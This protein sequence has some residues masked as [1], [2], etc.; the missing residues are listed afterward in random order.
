MCL[1]RVVSTPDRSGFTLV[2]LLVVILLMLVLAALAVLFVP[3]VNERR[4]SAIAAEQVQTALLTAKQR[5]VRDQAPR[6]VRIQP[7]P[8]VLDAMGD[9]S[10]GTQT[11]TPGG[12]TRG[13][14]SEGLVWSMQAPSWVIV[15]DPD[16]S[17]PN[18]PELFSNVE[19]VK[20]LSV[21]PPGTF[22]ATFNNRHSRARI[23]V[24]AYAQELHYIEQP[25]DYVAT[26]S[27]AGDGNPLRIRPI[28]V[29]AEP[30]AVRGRGQPSVPIP[31]GYAIVLHSYDR[32]SPPPGDF[33]GG[34][35][36]VPG[37][38]NTSVARYRQALWPVQRG[39]YVE[40]SGGGPVR[41]VRDVWP[42]QNSF[43]NPI[44]PPL[45]PPAPA[46]QWDGDVLEVNN[47]FPQSVTVETRNY[48]ILRAPRLLASEPPVKLPKD[49]AIDLNKNLLY[50]L[51]PFAGPLSIDSAT[52]NIDILFAPNGAVVSRGVSSDRINLWIRDASQDEID[53]KT[54]NPTTFEQTLVV[55]YVRTGFIAAFPVN[56]GW[57]PKFQPDP[58]KQNYDP[59]AYASP[60]SFVHS[61]AHSGGL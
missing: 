33:T 8:I 53:P 20:V 15:Y 3:R 49:V 31:P 28:T 57:N 52:G 39:D 27:L 13:V 4:K 48:R 38:T 36:F 51:T 16:P 55:T 58:T 17:A 45:P 10:Q 14:T 29:P 26:P 43:L 22:T 46:P 18:D 59:K 2:E 12:G 37:S 9:I 34:N 42:S 7:V 32:T 19:P 56:P 25:E 40:V 5:A 11:V 30:T 61:G 41:Q 47:P 1:Q 6:G 35:Y 54:G 44:S 24:L 23:K 50:A 60:Y 21:V